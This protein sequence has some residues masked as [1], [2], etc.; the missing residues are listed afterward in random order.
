[1]AVSG[2]LVSNLRPLSVDAVLPVRWAEES[3]NFSLAN[4]NEISRSTPGAGNN[5]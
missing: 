4:S 1:M 5:P 2:V 3:P